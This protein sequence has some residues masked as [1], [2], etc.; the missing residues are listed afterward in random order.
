MAGLTSTRKEFKVEQSI[1]ARFAE[2]VT[3]QPDRLA[4]AAGG[5]QPTY[6]ELE[7]ATN[8]FANLLLSRG[9]KP[10]DRIA[11]LMKHDAP[12]LAAVLSI[13]KAGRV[14]V[15]LN[16]SDPVTRL[17]QV[18]DDA[19]PFL[20]VAD[21]EHRQIAT[22]VGGDQRPVVLWDD[23][24]NGA[25]HGAGIPIAPGDIAWLV[26][27]SGS[28][29]RPKGVMQTHRN[30]LHNAWRL[31]GG[32]AISAEDKI[33]LFASPSGGQGVGTIW[34]AWAIGAALSPF[35]VVEKGVTGLVDW[36]DTHKV[37]VLITSASLFRHFVRSL[38][39]KHRFPSVR[40]VRLASESATAEDFAG[41]RKY[42]SR[43]CVLFNTLSSSETG[44]VF[45]HRLAWDS[46]IENGRIP[47]GRPAE[48]ME[49]LLIDEHGE[50]I[51]NGGVGE[52]VIRSGYLS[53]GYWRNEKLT[54]ERF[55]VDGGARR[56]RMGDLG[57]RTAEGIIEFK[58]RKD[59]QVKVRGYRI[60]VSEIESA[61]GRLAG[62]ERAVV[63]AAATGADL[64]LLAF[65]QARTGQ[66]VNVDKLK[67]ELG[68]V[69]PN[70]MVPSGFILVDRFPLTPTGKIDH[71]QLLELAK[72]QPVSEYA[73]PPKTE[74]EKLLVSLW[75]EVLGL[76]SVGRADDFIRLGGDSLKAAVLAARIYAVLEIELD[77]RVFSKHSK[78][79][80]LAELID[81]RR[82][83]S[84]GGN[85][86]KIKRAR[87]DEPLPMSFLQARTWKSSQSTEGSAG[88]TMAFSHLI[89]G[90]LNTEAFQASLDYLVRRH[91][92]L[93]TTFDATD[94]QLVQVIHPPMAAH[95]AFR[96]L[97]ADTNAEEVAFELFQK[98]AA[99][100]FHLRNAP[101]TRF[102]LLRIRPDEHWFYRVNHHIISDGWSWRIFFKELA[103][104]YEAKLRGVT[105]P[106]PEDEPLQFA[107]YAAWQR[108]SLNPSDQSYRRSVEWWHDRLK[109]APPRQALSSLRL[110]PVRNIGASEGLI[111]WTLKEEVADKLKELGRSQ[112]IT[113]F[114]TRLAAFAAQLA[115]EGGQPD[116]VIGSYTTNRN[117]I[118]V[119]GMFGF[120]ANLV[121]LRLRVKK[122]L[123]FL[124]WAAE[125][126]RMVGDV[127]AH[128]EIPYDQIVEEL[129]A[130]GVLVPDIHAIFKVIDR[131]PPMRLGDAEVSVLRRR[132]L[133]VM[134]WRFTVALAP[135]GEGGD[136]RVEFDA[137]M[138][139]PRKVRAWL[140]RYQGFL[141][142]ISHNPELSVRELARRSGIVRRN[143][144]V[145]FVHQLITRWT[146]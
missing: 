10:G 115:I 35:P 60:E 16:A 121:T 44:N 85:S 45:Q 61:L 54:A 62:V 73:Q 134:P 24:R 140:E 23:H 101:L 122:D 66:T 126:N 65:V 81:Q 57:S 123:S 142:A 131:V 118:E 18:V 80:E 137:R 91:E 124:D 59:S 100:V 46:A 69:L 111:H 146:A 116:V 96:D 67:E 103:A 139:D 33:S 93:R 125:V 4:I 70:H 55:S 128:G 90:T 119:Q 14:V 86:L 133:G 36:I 25:A 39:D 78:L 30:I 64:H 108:R 19:D 7:V 117:R 20:V 42:F 74:T 2:L 82:H 58:G 6:A 136:C 29:G 114:T 37:S 129:L 127:Q 106:I 76:R 72:N 47:V 31:T 52:I 1:P 77:L 22:E 105:P 48:G 87:R 8:R 138:H 53:P 32:L 38:D 13:L 84:P 109:E 120:F 5:W 94:G 63:C 79:N 51:T 97:A 98:E 110:L 9:G 104:V 11:I 144:F 102:L 40:I 135:Q 12:L 41:F 15:V 71:E 107:D 141:E 132:G 50:E 89:K 21:A 68:A 95:F 56:Y 17:S 43:D 26:Y 28:T 130:A 99:H 112:G 113:D 88:F 92:I 34:S 75:G 27:T 143:R 145:N 49:V 3:Q 83:E